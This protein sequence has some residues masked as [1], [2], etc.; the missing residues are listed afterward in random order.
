MLDAVRH[1]HRTVNAIAAA[2]D[3]TDNAVRAHLNALE[4]RGS[5]RRVG[6]VRSGGAGQ[7]AVEYEATLAAHIERSRAYP[8]A[9]RAV[10][11]TLA[12]RLDAAALRS[13]FRDAG[14]RLA[15]DAPRPRSLA[16]AARAARAVVNALG[17][18]VRV[19]FVN[20]HAELAAEGCPLAAA[21]AAE[22]AV[23][24][25]VES[26]L[27]QRTGRRVVQHCQHGA[28]PQCRF[29]ITNQTAGS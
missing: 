15:P 29:R 21:V 9:L 26:V 14:K 6:I 7:P 20:S 2:L 22:P 17:G 12:A 13:T 5:V 18:R 19:L 8:A 24:T 4:R 11:E 23:C 3:V 1:G 10:A 28:H 27:E 16:A 25:I